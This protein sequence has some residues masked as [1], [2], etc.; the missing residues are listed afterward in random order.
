MRT[1]L[2]LIFAG[3]LVTSFPAVIMAVLNFKQTLFRTIIMCLVFLLQIVFFIRA[4]TM[5]FPEETM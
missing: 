1:D 3:Q 2:V 5:V 4:I